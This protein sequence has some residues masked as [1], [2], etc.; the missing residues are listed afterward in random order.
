MSTSHGK[1]MMN[2]FLLGIRFQKCGVNL[3]ESQ[4]GKSLESELQKMGGSSIEVKRK[5]N[6]KGE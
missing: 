5:L 3:N 4:E 6:M 1:I 2:L